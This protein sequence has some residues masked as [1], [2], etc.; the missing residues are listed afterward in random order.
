MTTDIYKLIEQKRLELETQL[1]AAVEARDV[2][3]RNI[4]EIRAVIDEL[5]VRRTRR[6]RKEKVS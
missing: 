1:A 5:P 4:K 3:T 6:P 2:A